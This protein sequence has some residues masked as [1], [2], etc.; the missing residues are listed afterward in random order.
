MKTEGI[1][2]VEECIA[3]LA[4][5]PKKKAKGDWM[6]GDLQGSGRC[7]VFKMLW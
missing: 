7:P 4:G 2:E 3:Q 6:Q 5:L 1:S